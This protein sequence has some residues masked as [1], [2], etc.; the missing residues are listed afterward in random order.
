MRLFL[1]LREPLRASAAHVRR[2]GVAGGAPVNL[3][4][5]AGAPPADVRLAAV[6]RERQTAEVGES[7]VVTVADHPEQRWGLVHRSLWASPAAADRV[8][9][10]R[11]QRKQEVKLCRL[12][13]QHGWCFCTGDWF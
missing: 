9:P 1:R 5:E 2:G 4:S 13:A 11:A 10:E 3:R 8:L 6:D 12:R 7:R